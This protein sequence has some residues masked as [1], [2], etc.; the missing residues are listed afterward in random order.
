MAANRKLALAA[1]DLLAATLG[2]EPLV[3]AAMLGAMATLPLP[4]PPDTGPP[5]FADPLIDTLRRTWSI[6][7]PVFA[8]DGTR[9]FRISAQ[10][11][12]T[13]DQYQRLAEALT[14]EAT[15]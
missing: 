8:V 6:E 2:I 14:V 15:A 12:N 11:Y 13:I 1:R 4:G 9:V 7:V 5:G 10:L 3:P